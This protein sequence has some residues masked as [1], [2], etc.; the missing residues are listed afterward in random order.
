MNNQNQNRYLNI[1]KNGGYL[2]GQTQQ[3]NNYQ[4]PLQYAPQQ[5]PVY[6]AATTGNLPGLQVNSGQLPQ[7]QQN[8]FA[9]QYFPPNYNNIPVQQ[10]FVQTLP[11]QQQQQQVYPQPPPQQQQQQQQQPPPQQ[12]QQ[13]QQPIYQQQQY[14]QIYQQQPALPLQQTPPQQQ[15]QVYPPPPPQSYQTLP[16]YT[17]CNEY[18]QIKE[19]PSCEGIIF[20]PD[21]EEVQ[22]LE[23]EE[24]DHND[25]NSGSDSD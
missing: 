10:A 5:P 9:T 20:N 25:R 2:Q 6:A 24:E 21:E 23:Q 1:Y 4:P 14:Q 8:M 16:P 3:F 7:N 12:Q 17:D 13:Q 19:G 15:Q 22:T 18:Q 11:P